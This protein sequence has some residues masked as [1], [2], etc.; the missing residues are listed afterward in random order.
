MEPNKASV[1]DEL[2]FHYT[3][4]STALEHILESMTIR[5]GPISETHDPLEGHRENTGS[6][7]SP[8]VGPPNFAAW[9]KIG[10]TARCR[11]RLGNPAFA[12]TSAPRPV[13]AASG[14]DTHPC[15]VDAP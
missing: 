6:S 3:K 8:G 12:R 13:T 14:S 11:R 2:V 10:E 15:R 9:D 4:A 7:S 1:V 5:L